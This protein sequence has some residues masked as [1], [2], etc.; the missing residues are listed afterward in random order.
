[1]TPTI[2]S[3]VLRP[4]VVAVLILGFGVARP[5]PAPAHAVVVGT[6]P[7]D[8]TDV[9]ALPERIAVYL[10]AKPATVEGDP[11]AVYT[12]AGA[13]IDAGDVTV[14]EDGRLLSIGVVP[15]DPGA[16]HYQVEVVYRIVSADSHMISGHFGFH[17]MGPPGAAHQDYRAAQPPAQSSAWL[18]RGAPPDPRPLV[19]SGLALGALGAIGL[20]RRAR[21]VR[22]G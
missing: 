4:V 18:R 16:A 7:A 21:V 12:Q 1:M 20:R 22:R 13:R 2:R 8:G 11:L 9:D 14:S 5:S 10:D 17:V 6:A 19:L 3:A 15:A